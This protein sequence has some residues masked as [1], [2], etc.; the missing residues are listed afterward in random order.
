[1]TELETGPPFT[2]GGFAA[3]AAGGGGAGEAAAGTPGG[4]TSVGS[5]SRASIS[6]S[7][8]VA[9]LPLLS[10]LLLPL[11]PEVAAVLSEYE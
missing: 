11:L 10:A 9:A 2:G 8:G 4:T 7:E 5:D 6:G 3:L 1:M